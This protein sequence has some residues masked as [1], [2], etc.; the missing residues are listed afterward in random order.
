MRKVSICTLRAELAQGSANYLKQKLS[1]YTDIAE[2][3]DFGDSASF[4]E[5]VTDCAAKGGAVVAAAPVSVFLKAKLRLMKSVSPKIVRNSSILAA[6]G[7]NAPADPRERDLQAAIPENA[8]VIASPDGIFSGF[9]AGSKENPVIFIPL[10]ENILRFMFANGLGSYFAKLFLRAKPEAPKPAVNNLKSHIEKVISSGKTV[11]VSPVGCAKPLLSAISTVNGCEEAFVVDAALRDRLEGETTEEYVA[12]CAKI[13]KENSGTDLGIG[14]SPIY[15]EKNGSGDFVIVCVADSQRAKAAKVYAT[16]GEDKKHLIVAAVIKLCEMLDELTVTGLVNPNPPAKQP[17]KWSKNSKTPMIIAIAVLAV[18]IIACVVFAFVL[19]NKE[20][21]STSVNYEG[22]NGYVQDI[23]NNADDDASYEDVYGNHGGSPLDPF[24]GFN[25][26][27]QITEPESTFGGYTTTSSTKFTAFSTT[28]QRIT[29]T[30]TR[31]LTTL[32]TTV[33]KITTT[34]KTTAATTTKPTT[35][36]TT[37]ATTTTTKATTTTTTTKPTTTKKPADVSQGVT[38]STATGDATFENGS[39]GTFVFRVYGYG[40]GVGMS[41]DGAIKMA[42][43]G[44]TY[45]QILTNYFIGTTVKTDSSTPATVKYGEKDIPLVEYLCRT[46]KPEIGAGAP[47]EALKA[48]IVCAYTYAK[49]YDFD[50]AKSRHAYDSDY[51]YVGTNIHK[52]CLAVLGMSSDADT[53]KAPYVDYNG[54]AAFTCYFANA[55]GKTASATSVWGGGESQYP[56]LSGGAKSPETVDTSTVE[57]S[58]EDMKKLIESYAKDNGID[59]VLDSDPAKWLSIK[60]HDSSYSKN[61]GYVTTMKVGNYEVK[62]NT[63]RSYV[64]DFKL[65]SHCFTFEYVP[66]PAPETTTAATTT[67]TTAS[68]QSTTSSTS[69]T[70]S[71]TQSA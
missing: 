11:A 50:V 36:A 7:A 55:A 31:V 30:T 29:T 5:G 32:A 47:T 61:I 52:A 70:T 6:M 51:D 18:A 66:A 20:P 2:I 57:I 22:S 1:A 25:E 13:S 23:Q 10:E 16:P 17:K 48:Q 3:K 65:R 40:H 53:P 9:M 21:D 8:A 38:G 46:T 41:Q 58:V 15:N 59:I 28:V 4:A 63:F 33:S 62:G 35:A 69:A 56:Y 26:P 49:W 43:D 68:E 24:E 12:Q 39:K 34:I 37:T 60:A 27:V 45:D 54:K 44:S 42:K 64:V 71:E 19:G 14:I 67:T